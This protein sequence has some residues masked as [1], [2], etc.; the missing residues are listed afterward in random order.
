MAPTINPP[1]NGDRDRRRQTAGDRKTADLVCRVKYCNT[2]PDIP[3][4]PKFILYPFDTNRFIQ[5]NAT[6]LEKNYKYELLAEHDLGITIDLINP[7]AYASTSSSELHPD[8]EKLLEE[9]V[10]APQDTKRSARHAIPVSWLRR[11]EYISTEATR[12]QPTTMDKVEAKVGF[13]IK[14]TFKEDNF[15]LDHDSQIRAIEKTF[16]DAKKPI[17]KHY[18]KP[19]V[20]AVEVLPI[21]PDF[22]LWKYP[23]AQVIFDADPAPAG[24]SVP[25]QLEEMSQA[26]IRGVMDETGEQF[27]AYFLPTQETLEKRATDLSE[28][29]DYN[30]SEEYDYKMARQYHW[31]VKSKASKGYEENYFFVF[32]N[33]QVLY[34]ELET[35]VRLTKRRPKPGEPATSNT[36]LVLHHRSLTSKEHRMLRLREKQLEPANQM[37]D[38]EE[39][40]DEEEEEEEDA[41]A[42]EE[43]AAVSEANEDGETQEKQP[44][45]DNGSESDAQ[46]ARSRSRSKSR[47]RSRSKSA[48]SSSSARSRSSSA[49][50]QHSVASAPKDEP[51]HEGKTQQDNKSNSSSNSSSSSSSSSSDSSSSSS[52][53]E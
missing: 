30:D 2:L 31:N 46:S 27:V 18:S 1:Q 40:D 34:N 6:S 47:S 12:F 38:E 19:G 52:D 9:D 26:M 33:N 23:C 45:A 25:V 20:T 7:Q 32:R 17:E 22:N 3:F 42:K 5:Y 28:G 35:R 11:T 44:A 21:L 4:D 37:D 24:R 51:E 39:I 43:T 10:H 8:D 41:Q 36:R 15:Y 13:S 53:S 14:K 48:S 16:E 29:I 50:S 49:S